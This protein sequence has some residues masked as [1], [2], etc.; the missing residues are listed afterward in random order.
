MMYYYLTEMMKGI[1]LGLFLLGITIT[2]LKQNH[3]EKWLRSY[4]LNLAKIEARK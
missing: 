4:E 3:Y 1:G 2:K